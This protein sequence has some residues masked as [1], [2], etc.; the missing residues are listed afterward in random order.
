MSK[1]TITC[2]IN[3]D[4][5]SAKSQR[6]FMKIELSASKTSSK[7]Q[8]TL[9]IWAPHILLLSRKL[10]KEKKIA[11]ETLRK[12]ESLIKMLARTLKQR[13]RTRKTL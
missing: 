7:F 9:P 8:S 13:R 11:L 2:A 1:L 10:K 3:K 5:I 6:L 4:K 12:L